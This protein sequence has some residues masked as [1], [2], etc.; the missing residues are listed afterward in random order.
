MSGYWL[1]DATVELARA[2][3]QAAALHQELAMRDYIT[4]DRVVAVR[5]GARCV[6]C[7]A[8]L[9]EVLV[10]QPGEWVQVTLVGTAYERHDCQPRA[11]YAAPASQPV[12]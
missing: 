10:G 9:V 7:L 5:S 3:C 6:H 2:D 1:R 4:A 11:W 8:P 12:E